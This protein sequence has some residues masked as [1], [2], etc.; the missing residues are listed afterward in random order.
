MRLFRDDYGP[1]NYAV[2]WNSNHLLR[3]PTV[4]GFCPSPRSMTNNIIVEFQNKKTTIEYFIFKWV[5]YS[6]KGKNNL[7]KLQG[8]QELQ[9]VHEHVCDKETATIDRVKNRDSL[10]YND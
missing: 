3:S 6:F 10:K 5:Y 1:P 9:E 7:S 2:C 4:T 8:T